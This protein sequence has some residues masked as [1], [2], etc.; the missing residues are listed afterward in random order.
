MAR[1][2]TLAT[3]TKNTKPTKGSS[4]SLAVEPIEKVLTETDEE[5]LARLQIGRAHV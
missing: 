4:M 2:M 1:V 5:I 3:M